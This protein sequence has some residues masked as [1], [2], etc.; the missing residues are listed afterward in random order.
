MTTHA[1]PTA[2]DFFLDLFLPVHSPAFF[3]EK[4]TSPEFFSV[5]AVTNTGACVGP[6]SKVGHP[7]RGPAE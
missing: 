3:P 5:L 4:K 7:A 6:Q 2:S 1:S